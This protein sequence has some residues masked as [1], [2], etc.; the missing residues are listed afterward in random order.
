MT[1]AHISM[2]NLQLTAAA[3]EG[4]V[5]AVAPEL[6][7]TDPSYHTWR[8]Q[9]PVIPFGME[10]QPEAYARTLRAALPEVTT[11]RMG[12]DAW[13]LNANGALA[14]QY[15]RFLNEAVRQGFQIVLVYADGEIQRVGS[16]GD[17]AAIEDVLGG[18]AHDRMMDAWGRMFDWL[19]TRP[20]IA[21]AVWGVEAVNEPAGYGRGEDLV[22]DGRFVRMYGDHMAEFAAL[23]QART[24]ARLLIG[25]WDYSASFD[26]LAQTAARD[27]TGS[28][29]DQIRAAAGADLVWSAHLY[30]FWGQEAGQ[31][32][33]G[34]ARFI[35]RLYGVLGSDDV[36]MTE[37]NAPGFQVNDPT[38]ANMPFWMA[39]AYEVLRDTGIGIGW[40]PGAEFGASSLVAIDNGTTVR[41]RHPDSF[42]H[43]TNA[44]LLGREDAARA[45]DEDVSA[46]LLPGIVSDETRGRLDLD[47]LGYAAGHGGNDVLRG[48]EGAMNMLYG[49]TGQDSLIGAA[50]RDHLFG[51]DGHDLLSG[52][53]GDDV[54]GGGDGDDTLAG[55]GGDDLLTGGRGRDRFLIETSGHDVIADFYADEG[56]VLVVDGQEMNLSTL[57]A[58]AASVDADNDGQSDDGRIVWAGGSLTVLNLRALRPDGVIDGTTSN[59]R[60]SVGFVD[61]H[62]DAYTWK[63]A[64]VSGGAGDDEILGSVSDDALRGGLGDDRLFGRGGRD[65]LYGE[66]GQDRLEGKRGEDLLDGGTGHD[67]LF[68]YDGNDTFAGGAG[69]DV[70]YGGSGDDQMDGGSGDDTVTGSLGQ[71][72]MD[73]GSGHD[74]MSG[75]QGNDSIEGGSGNDTLWGEAGRDTLFGGSGNDR[76]GGGLDADVLIGGSGSDWLTGNA[77]ND[78][79]MG[80]IGNDRL[81]GGSGH[82]ILVG[83]G[84]SDMLQGDAGNDRLEAALAGR[85]ACV[86]SGGSGRDTFVFALG[87]DR[88]AGRATVTDFQPGVDQL[89][90]NGRQGA[91]IEASRDFQRLSQV[92]DDAVLRFGGDIVIFEDV[93]I[94]DLW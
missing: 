7:L 42:A 78:R 38:A 55:E 64:V 2:I 47:G 68:G 40:Y 29:L 28:V 44:F 32:V 52:G 39:R 70:L 85:V 89:I 74:L 24:D 62:S 18:T 17:S 11:L 49:G 51:Q 8:T 84:G 48:I 76:L 26:I 37:T 83:G 33:D 94:A 65:V 91:E 87:G 45:G 93:R 72:R 31:G 35:A 23:A 75:G 41:Y 6:E 77:G 61:A 14:P 86:L 4:Y 19:D 15:Q 60:I 73:G 22:Q 46:V 10:D 3:V 58:Q 82:D 21:R 67:T 16:M 36:L 54:L 63:G 79:L 69:H 34:F 88:I 57:L 43:A 12:F 25:G 5:S 30:P 80:G 20:E 66:A 56:D 13:T 90:V 50:G 9:G 53:D 1:T 71:D 92:G 27:G 59:D 81:F